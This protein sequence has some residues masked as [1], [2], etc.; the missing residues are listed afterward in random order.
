MGEGEF[1]L[2]KSADF[3]VNACSQDVS[4]NRQSNYKL[5]WNRDFAITETVNGVKYDVIVDGGAF[6]AEQEAVYTIKVLK[7]GDVQTLG[8]TKYAF[9]GNLGTHSATGANGWDCDANRKKGTCKMIYKDSELV[10]RLARSKKNGDWNAKGHRLVIKFFNT[11]RLVTANIA[12][13]GQNGGSAKF[14]QRTLFNIM[15]KVPKG[16]TTTGLCSKSKADM[17]PLR[18]SKDFSDFVPSTLMLSCAAGT[19]TD[20]KDTELEVTELIEATTCD[21][22]AATTAVQNCAN[23]LSEDMLGCVL[24][25]LHACGEADVAPLIDFEEDNVPYSCPA[26]SYI[27]SNSWPIT[28]FDDCSCYW[29][30]SKKDD[31]DAA[32]PETCQPDFQADG[33]TSPTALPNN[34]ACFCDGGSDRF[35]MHKNDRSCGYGVKTDGSTCYLREAGCQCAEGTYDCTGKSYTLEF[36]RQPAL[37][38]PQTPFGTQPVVVL[39]DQDGKVVEDSKTTVRVSIAN[40]QDK[41]C[42]CGADKPCLHDNVAD[43]T[44]FGKQNLFGDMVCPAGTTECLPTQTTTKLFQKIM[45]E[46]PSNPNSLE[47]KTTQCRMHTDQDYLDSRPEFQEQVMAAGA[48]IG[49]CSGMTPCKHKGDGH[50][51]PKTAFA[52]HDKIPAPVDITTCKGTAAWR[53]AVPSPTT[54]WFFETDTSCTM[55]GTLGCS[56]QGHS[57]AMDKWC[58]HNCHPKFPGQPAFCPESHCSC[59]ATAAPTG[60]EADYDWKCPADRYSDGSCRCTAGTEFCGAIEEKL[61]KGDGSFQHLTIG[62]EGR[63]QLLAEIVMPDQLTGSNNVQ[64]SSRSAVFDVMYPKTAGTTCRAQA[65]WR[66]PAMYNSEAHG[67]GKAWFYEDSKKCISKHADGNCEAVS[68]T[69]FAMDKWC[70]ANKCAEHTLINHCEFYTPDSSSVTSTCTSGL[71]DMFGDCC[72]SAHVDQ[73]GVCNG[74]GSTCQVISYVAVP[75]DFS[76]PEIVFDASLADNTC[77]PKLPCMHLN[78]G[79]CMPK[80]FNSAVLKGT[81]QHCFYDRSATAEQQPHYKQ[82]TWDV[83]GRMSKS[84]E[85]SFENGNEDCYCAAGTVDISKKL[86]I[87]EEA[88]EEAFKEIDERINGKPEEKDQAGNVVTPEVPGIG[89]PEEKVVIDNSKNLRA[90]D[91]FDCPTDGQYIQLSTNYDNIL[92]G[93][94]FE[95]SNTHGSCWCGFAPTCAAANHPTCSNDLIRSIMLPPMTTAKLFKHCASEHAG[96]QIRYPSLENFGTTP[97]CFNFKDLNQLDGK[98]LTADDPNGYEQLDVSMIQIE[99]AVLKVKADIVGTISACYESQCVPQMEDC[100]KDSECGK[101]MKESEYASA[102]GENF[103]DAMQEMMAGDS[104]NKNAQ[105][106]YQCIKTVTGCAVDGLNSKLS[107]LSAAKKIYPTNTFTQDFDLSTSFF[108]RRRLVAGAASGSAVAQISTSGNQGVMGATAAGATSS[109]QFAGAGSQAGAGA[110]STASSAGVGTAGAVGI[111]VGC[112][113]IAA[114]AVAFVV[115]QKQAARPVSNMNAGNTVAKAAEDHTDVL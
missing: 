6:T 85:T 87:E 115:Q 18:V 46:D 90:Y 61:V 25:G 114:L 56:E 77:S 11:H 93:T 109:A 66:Q 42:Q 71:Y 92:C 35:C 49:F 53:R 16:E 113:A 74:D 112:T 32:N 60:V 55:T 111:A 76:Q 45:A 105:A 67:E 84:I 26:N 99:G 24:D 21:L 79:H 68:E 57:Y 44:C 58:D 17:K 43:N 78:D 8:T 75:V 48:G 95:G 15:V 13:K 40:A 64:I 3:Q 39:K 59:T 19:A 80:T 52:N 1:V 88:A 62:T 7:D 94:H 70:K 72:E 86:I 51:M 106:L 28:D 33:L 98:Q 36:K 14:G 20:V 101:M 81:A 104:P 110:A 12:T 27:S 5:T 108:E 23:S 4:I 73:C 69:E 91:G 30:Y 100:A 89:T 50:C 29:G 22:A 10:V 54:G 41:S 83:E 37:A 47:A 63:Y 31:E 96:E 102:A 103:A 2:A 107:E 82:G 9:D 38:T 34:V 97:K 65:Q